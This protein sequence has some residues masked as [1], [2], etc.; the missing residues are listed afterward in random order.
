M[1]AERVCAGC[2]LPS[3]R[4]RGNPPL[5]ACHYCIRMTPFRFESAVDEWK[6]ILRAEREEKKAS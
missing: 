5:R 1:K 2:G 3:V 4:L 6:R